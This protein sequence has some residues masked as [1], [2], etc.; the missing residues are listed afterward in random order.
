M[1]KEIKIITILMA[2]AVVLAANVCAQQPEID[3]D[4]GK[5]LHPVSRYLTGRVWRT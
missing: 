4:M 2:L 5:V 3:V 1:S